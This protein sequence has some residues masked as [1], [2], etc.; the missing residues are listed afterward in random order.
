MFSFCD[1]IV[2]YCGIAA[3]VC[4]S[5]SY[6]VLEMGVSDSNRVLMF[7][8][9]VSCLLLLSIRPLLPRLC[10]LLLARRFY[11]LG[12]GLG[13]MVVRGQVK[14]DEFL[15]FADIEIISMKSNLKTHLLFC[16]L[17]FYMR[18]VGML[19]TSVVVVFTFDDYFHSGGG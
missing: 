10:W 7:L 18:L 2:F 1:A 6:F 11:S 4:A 17:C 19:K 13:E 14:P 5:S 12:L 8:L 15:V 16:L 3:H 9:L